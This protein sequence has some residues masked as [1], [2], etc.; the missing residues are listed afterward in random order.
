MKQKLKYLLPGEATCV[1]VSYEVEVRMEG[2]FLGS[3]EG[4][5]PRLSACPPAVQLLHL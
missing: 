2:G 1:C 4:S 3:A 5:H